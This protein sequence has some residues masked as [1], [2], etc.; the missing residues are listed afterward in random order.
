VRLRTVKP[1]GNLTTLGVGSSR[2]GKTLPSMVPG[3]L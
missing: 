1:Q 3:L 2:P